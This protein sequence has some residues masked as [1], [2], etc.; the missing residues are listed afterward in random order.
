MLEL[1]LERVITLLLNAVLENI[2]VLFRS[3]SAN[4]IDGIKSTLF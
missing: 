1:I 2:G 3:N 4:T